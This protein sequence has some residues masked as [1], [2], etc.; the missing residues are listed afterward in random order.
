MSSLLLDDRPLQV[1]PKLAIR[2]GLNEAIVLQQLHWLLQGPAN[3]RK[4]AEHKWIFNTVDEWRA[5]YFQFWSNRTIK[6][7]FSNLA[8]MNLIETC[9]P[10]GRL[11]RRKYYRVNLEI[12]HQISEGAKNVPSKGKQ[13]S[14]GNGQNSSLPITETSANTSL[15]RK[16]EEAKETAKGFADGVSFSEEEHS[17]V[18]KP[19]ERTKS[20]KLKA[21]RAPRDFPSEREFHAFIEES[22]LDKLLMSRDTDEIYRNLCCNKWRQWRGNQWVRIYDWRAYVTALN[23]KMEDATGNGF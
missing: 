16:S 4:I 14:V 5:Q 3:G 23:Q 7:I 9:Q 22:E 20:A 11:S 12:V 15:Q 1:L 19:D 21:I 13:S 2:I 8:R 10:E 17:A 18:W 6:T